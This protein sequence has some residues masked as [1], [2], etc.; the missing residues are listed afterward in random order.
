M[1]TYYV[2]SQAVGANS[3]ANKSDAF[4]ASPGAMAAALAAATTNGDVILVHKQHVEVFAATANLTALADI[5]IIVIDFATDALAEMDGTNYYL[6]GTNTVN[7]G[8]AFK[9]FTSG[10]A[11]KQTSA[12]TCIHEIA[13]TDGSQY[14]MENCK[15]WLNTGT[16]SRLNLGLNTGRNSY[17]KLVNPDIKFGN[18]LQYLQ[19]F[20][21]IEAQGGGVS[22]T[23]PNVLFGVQSLGSSL[24]DISLDSMDLSIIA[25]NLLASQSSR[26]VTLRANNCTLHASLTP[27]AT[28]APANMGAGEVWLTDCAAGD[29]HYAF[30]HSNPLGR[31]TISS[32]IYANDNPTYDGTNKCS[33]KITTTANV[34]YWSPYVSPWI[35]KLPASVGAAVTPSFEVL[36]DGSATAYNNDEVWAEFA[37]KGTSGSCKLTFANDRKALLAGAVPQATSSKSAGDWT[38]ENATAWFGTL[39]LGSSITPQEAGYIRGRICVGVPSSTLYVDPN[40]RGI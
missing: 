3:G 39:G 15:L 37:Y 20:G 40:I 4:N 13:Q 18:A 27:L 8:G 2:N 31:L 5:S 34:S 6:G 12:A 32:T 36:R 1:T 10:L 24:T 30:D 14:I 21:R 23:A 17:V 9:V 26:P 22:G 33:W 38:G 35:D 29:I 7:L 25:G 19:G 11:F 28:Q 16:G